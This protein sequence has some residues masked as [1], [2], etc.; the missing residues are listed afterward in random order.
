[1]L[2][3][4][5]FN[6]PFGWHPFVEDSLG[7]TVATST[8]ERKWFLDALTG[9]NQSE[10]L[11]IEYLSFWFKLTPRTRGQNDEEFKP[12]LE[13]APKGRNLRK[14]G[15]ADLQE[16][17]PNPIDSF[18]VLPPK[19][20]EWNVH[21]QFITVQGETRPDRRKTKCSPDMIHTLGHFV[22]DPQL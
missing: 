17:R 19:I 14:F 7:A 8:N 5:E 16:K 9:L 1:M 20:V 2:Y 10:F 11:N 13:R 6:S 18:R 12:V 22:S 21:L 4:P 3:A 15:R